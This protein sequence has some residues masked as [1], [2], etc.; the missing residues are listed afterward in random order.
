MN[1]SLYKTTVDHVRSK[2]NPVHI[3]T[4]YCNIWRDNHDNCM[5]C[6]S[7]AGCKEVTN[8]LLTIAS[9]MIH[10]REGGENNGR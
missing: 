6:E 3:H 4:P 7:A 2:G 1:D 9:I 8:I 10:N 5:G